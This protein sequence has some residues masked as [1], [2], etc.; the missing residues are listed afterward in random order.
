MVCVWIVCDIPVSI[1]LGK[2]GLDILSLSLSLLHDLHKR[3]S[4]F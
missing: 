3:S 2:L 1:I 4:L